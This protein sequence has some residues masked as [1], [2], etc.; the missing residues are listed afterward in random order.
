MEN[1][2]WRINI[3]LWRLAQNAPKLVF[4]CQGASGACQNFLPSLFTFLKV[5][6]QIWPN[7]P[8]FTTISL[9]HWF[10]HFSVTDYQWQ[11]FPNPIFTRHNPT[12]I[13]WVYKLKWT[14]SVITQTF[15]L[16]TLL[17][18]LGDENFTKSVYTVYTHWGILHTMYNFRERVYFTHSV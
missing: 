14:L 10:L 11:W 3:S 6:I 5:T 18:H 8:T 7:G 4:T 15:P 12:R 16:K 2:C 17:N 9:I 1:I 13:G